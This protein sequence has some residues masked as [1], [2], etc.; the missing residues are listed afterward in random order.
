MTQ[1]I[2][3]RFELLFL[4]LAFTTFITL[5]VVIGTAIAKRSCTAKK[6]L[7]V[8][9]IAW[10]AYLAIVLVV[11]AFT[12]QRVIA[13]NRDLCMDEMCFAVVNVQT[14]S[15]LG[16]ASHPVRAMGKFYIVTVR[17][18]SHARGRAQ[19]E[20]GLRAVLWSPG[21]TYA[22]SENGQAAWEAAHPENAALTTRLAPGQAVLSDQVFDTSSESR[23]FG[24]VLTNGFTPGYFVIGECPL[25][26]KPT[27]L[28]LSAE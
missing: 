18:S 19:S 28:R 23:D 10:G 1:T 2:D 20:R 24:L 11:A 12:P 16:P 13:M 21:H 14:A 4:L 27:I 15:Q 26:H 5:I 22:V 17:A 8:I 25:L 7:K 3:F 9:G 6:L